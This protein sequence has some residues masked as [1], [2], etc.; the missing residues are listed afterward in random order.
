MT[1][2]PQIDALALGPLAEGDPADL[3]ADADL[4]S[5]RYADLTVPRLDLRDALVESS[6]LV[7]LAADEA[8]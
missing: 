6:Q 7:G 1:K 3:T 2:A 4:D 8:D 5:V